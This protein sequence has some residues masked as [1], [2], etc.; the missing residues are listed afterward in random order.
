MKNLL[1]ALFDNNLTQVEVNEVNAYFKTV[2]SDL[3]AKVVG[4]YEELYDE[5]DDS[6]NFG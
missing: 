2:M 6:D 1:N 3:E 4:P 5:F